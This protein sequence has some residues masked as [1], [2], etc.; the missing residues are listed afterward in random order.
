LNY[1]HFNPVGKK[2]LLSV[3]DLGYH[4]SS[5]RFYENGIDEFGFLKNI[6]TVFDGD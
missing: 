2:W 4:F 1:I 5:A 3:D 6:F